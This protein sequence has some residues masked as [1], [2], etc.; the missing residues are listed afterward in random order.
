MQILQVV[1]AVAHGDEQVEPQA[2]AVA[3]PGADA[4]ARHAHLRLHGARP[5]E[6]VAAAD[7]QSEIVG[8]QVSVTLRCVSVRKLRTGEDSGDGDAGLQTLFPE[9]DSFE[10]R[11]LV[12][13]GGA[14]DGRILQDADALA[15]V[16]ICGVRL[17][18]TRAHG[19]GT[20]HRRRRVRHPDGAVGIA[21]AGVI[22]LECPGVAA[23]IELEFGEVVAF[24]EVFE[25]GGEDLGNFVD[26]VELSGVGVVVLA[27][28]EVLEVGRVS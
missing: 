2:R 17:E 24:V 11:E 26:E 1:E 7:D 13:L 5:L 28:E 8:A 18:G 19:C 9:C 22:I 20:S 10:L 12:A 21:W 27:V 15:G 14:V 6:G 23:A 16:W 4:R 25:D 3:V